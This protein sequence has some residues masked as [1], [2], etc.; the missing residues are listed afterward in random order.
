MTLLRLAVLGVLA[1]LIA[2]VSTFAAQQKPI[3]GYVDES[4]LVTLRG[5]VRPEVTAANDRGSVEDST[6]FHDLQL[7]LHRNPD[8]EADAELYF[9]QLSDPSSPNYHK[10]LTNTQIGEMFGPAKQDIDTVKLWLETQGF[11]V[12][13]VSPDRTVV[14]FSGD[15]KLVR[16]AFHTS[17]HKLR[18]NGEEHFANVSD[19]QIPADLTPVVTGIA[20]LTDFM[21]YKMSRSRVKT[22]MKQATRNGVPSSGSGAVAYLG[23]A[24]LAK[25]YNFTPLLTSGVTGKGQTIAV[26]EDTNLYSANDWT[27]FRQNLGLSIYTFGTLTQLNPAGTN[28][29]GN[30]GTNGDDGEAAIDVEW[31]TAAAPD[32]AIINAAC[33]DT[34]QFGGF[35]ALANLL[36]GSTV[37]NVVSISYGESES[38][39]GVGENAYIA[40][41][42]FSAALQG[43]SL[44]VSSGDEGAA[45]SDANKSTAAHGISVSG[46]TS[47]PYNVSVG[48][49]DF[50]PTYLNDTS[51]YF[52]STNG[53]NFLTALSYVPE[54]PWNDSCASQLVS[55]YLDTYDNDSY[56]PLTL[57][58]SGNFLTTASGSGGP[59]GCASGAPA[60]AGVV[61]GTCAGYS[62]PSWQS[63]LGNPSDGVRDIPDVSLMAANGFWGY[64]Y[65]VCW[66]DPSYKA[67]GSTA[68]CGTDPASWSGFGGTS[69]SSPIWAGIQALLNQLTGHNWGL[70][71]PYLYALANRQY[72]TEGSTN[73]NSSLGNGVDCTCV[74]YD[75]T[76]GDMDT[77]CKKD[78]SSGTFDCYLPSG[79]TGLLSTTNS[80]DQPAYGTGLGWDFATGIGTVNVRNFLFAFAAQF[81]PPS[82]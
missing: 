17:I 13:S 78:G 18:V 33:S 51:T 2:P 52:S 35:L 46:Y 72:G 9:Q 61:S 3:L 81:G 1:L 45:S 67:D 48:G 14:E 50:A 25:I 11:K 29:C 27:T 15:A 79:S 5:N 76:L 71:T 34:T 38:E 59:S 26:I 4:K 54:I 60:H 37:P 23:A 39:L 32:A 31:A 42:Y 41:L 68:S 30:P 69:I 55:N 73:C 8:A 77:P 56:T 20:S 22:S 44:F 24:D 21:P 66:T 62:K 58:Q 6:S 36:Q 43:V 12:K 49:T 80:A 64:Y 16:N 75:I 10:W 19:P 28:S 7:V 47:T 57:C 40:N 82:Q 70:T 65:A 53:T 63:V 74:F